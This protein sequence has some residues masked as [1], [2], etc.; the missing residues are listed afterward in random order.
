MAAMSNIRE[1]EY[2]DGVLRRTHHPIIPPE[3]DLIRSKRCQCG[4]RAVCLTTGDRTRRGREV[5]F[6]CADAQQWQRSAEA[7]VQKEL[8]RMRLRMHELT[9]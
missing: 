5:M 6:R 2:A 3:V 7:L 9:L 8:R 1:I 4:A